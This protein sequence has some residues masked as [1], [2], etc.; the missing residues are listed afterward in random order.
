MSGWVI[1]KHPGLAPLQEE[2]NYGAAAAHDITISYHGKADVAVASDIVGGSEQL[3]GAEFGRAIQ[4]DRRGGLVGR[5][6]DNPLH[7]SVKTGLD[8]VLRTQNIG[9]DRLKRIIF[10]RRHLLECG[11]VD[12]DIDALHRPAQSV[13]VA[14]VPNEIAH[15]RVV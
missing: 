2:R 13:P 8:D 11:G 6:G 10:G 3:V 1:W 14:H 12:D 9:P 7:S 5:Q 15:R 4:A